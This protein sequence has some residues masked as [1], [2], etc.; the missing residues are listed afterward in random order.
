MVSLTYGIIRAM[1]NSQRGFLKAIIIIICAIFIL[2]LVA[3]V[4]LYWQTRL[5]LN[6]ARNPQIQ[7][8]GPAASTTSN[9]Y[10]A[11]AKYDSIIRTIAE[12]SYNGK[13]YSGSLI[14][15]N[16]STNN[17]DGIRTSSSFVIAGM[18]VSQVIS[19]VSEKG[20]KI[21]VITNSGPTQYAVYGQSPDDS[22]KYFC[23]DSSGNSNQS[24][25]LGSIKLSCN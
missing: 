21:F 15:N 20:E 6:E 24:V 1:K 18:T 7:T 25:G 5:A 4:F 12:S 16:I 2:G 13:D 22:T 11:I 3:I 8:S 19:A 9:I 10:E 17:G 23:L 14:P